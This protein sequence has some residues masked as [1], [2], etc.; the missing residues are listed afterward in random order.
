MSRMYLAQPLVPLH[1]L[2]GASFA[3]FTVNQDV[4]PDPGIIIP[5][6][7]L[8]VGSELWLEADGEYLTTAAVTMGFGFFYGAVATTVLAVGTALTSGAQA[9]SWPWHA[10]WKGR[11]RAVGPTGSIQGSGWWILGTS[12]TT[13]SAPQAMPVTKVLRTVAL[14]TTVASEVGVSAVCGTSAAGNSVQVNRFSAMLVS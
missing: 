12:L 5:A 9:I 10:E 11:V 8:E 13:F 4:T 14:N 6:N 7:M 2:D 3:S 1:V